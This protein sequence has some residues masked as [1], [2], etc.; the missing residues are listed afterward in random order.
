LDMAFPK[1][2][3]FGCVCADLPPTLSGMSAAVGTS[4]FQPLPPGVCG[5]ILPA[6]ISLHTVVSP[7]SV[8]V[9]PELRVTNADG[10]L[11]KEINGETPAKALAEVTR[12]AGPLEQLLV[13][14]SGFLLGLEAPRQHSEKKVWDGAESWGTSMR[15]PSYSAMAKQSASSDWLVRSIEPSAD[16]TLVIRREDLKKVPRRVGPAWLRCQLHVRDL[17]WARKELQLMLQRYLSV[18]MFLQNLQAPFG[19]LVCQCSTTVSSQK[20]A[21]DE[22]GYTEL[23]D[24]LGKDLPITGALSHGEVAPPGIYMGGVENKRV[25]RQGHTVS[26]CLFSYE[27]TSEDVAKN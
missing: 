10:Y 5:L 18:R 8:R 15:A 17:R 24:V 11:V 25:T 26:M 7:G 4:E 22:L 19:A 14:R 13:E 16:G 23:R 12:G 2:A 9:G 21:E 20:T 3:K 6:D 1:A 27:P